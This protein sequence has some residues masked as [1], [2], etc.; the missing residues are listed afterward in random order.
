MFRVIYALH[1]TYGMTLNVQADCSELFL[2]LLLLGFRFGSRFFFISIEA[3]VL[4]MPFLNS[5]FRKA[6]T[7]F[8]SLT[9]VNP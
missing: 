8:A 1:E 4:L 5:V 2:R 3:A 7:V 6:F 9:L